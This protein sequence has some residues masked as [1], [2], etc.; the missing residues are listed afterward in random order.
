MSTSATTAQARAD[1]QQFWNGIAKLPEPAQRSFWDAGASLSRYIGENPSPRT[2]TF[3]T[4]QPPA[5]AAWWERLLFYVGQSHY[6]QA[7]ANAHAG[8]AMV[9]GGKWLWGA[10]QGDF[11]K[12]P[13]TGQIITGGI[14]SLIPI[15][16]QACDVRDL[17]A[18]CLD[19]ND[20]ES[21]EDSAKWMAL[22]LTCVGFVPEFGSAVKTVAKVGFKEGTQL[23]GLLKHM[24]WIEKNFQKLKMACPW[25]YAPIE[26]LRKYDWVGQLQKAGQRAQKAF[27]NAL[28]KARTAL[29][30]AIGGIRTRLQ[31]LVELFQ[32]IA[33]KI[34]AVMTELGQKLKAKIGEML[35]SAKKQA[36]NYDATPGKAPNKHMQGEAEPPK[37][38]PGKPPRMD[39]HKPKCF[40]PGD[41]L[42][43]GWKGDP[44]KLEKEFYEQLKAQEKGIND[45]TVGEYLENRAKF[46]AVG[47]G[48]GTA[49]EAAREALADDIERSVFNSA[50]RNGMS[51]KEAAQ[52]AQGKTKDI[53]GALAALHDPDMI[54]GGHDKIG[55]FGDRKVN[56]SLGSQWSKEG[57]VAEMDK[58]AE[59]ALKA[60]GPDARMNVTLERCK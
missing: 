22:G 10:L 53:M 39:P 18:N 2:L 19:L 5:G 54:A 13:T 51:A 23:L 44:N 29:K 15:V 6:N 37:G 41:D 11:N 1:N 33:G 14:I 59:Q 47:R 8:Q 36:G 27:E 48:N 46:N 30:Y 31:Q 55:G 28:Q 58:A 17:I 40:K 60:Q 21:R 34:A 3:D 12:S 43:K 45:L 49:Q 9:D 20:A 50:K 25:G 32:A 38:P 7:V 42:K 57:R 35:G 4:S 56:S 24:E 26:W 52:Y 16:D